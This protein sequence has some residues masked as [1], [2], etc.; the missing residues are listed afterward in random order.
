MVKIV[1]WIWKMPTKVTYLKAS[2]IL[3]IE[4]PEHMHFDCHQQAQSSSNTNLKIDGATINTPPQT[5]TLSLAQISRL[6]MFM[7]MF[8]TLT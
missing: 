4:V 5:N 8:T 6:V 1:L 2:M 3:G 7:R